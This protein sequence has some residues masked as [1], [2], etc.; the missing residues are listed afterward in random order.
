MRPEENGYEDWYSEE[1]SRLRVR[2]D[3]ESIK[4]DRDR[5]RREEEGE[6]DEE[7]SLC[8]VTLLTH[9]ALS[10]LPPPTRT[11]REPGEAAHALPPSWKSH[12]VFCFAFSSVQIKVKAHKPHLFI[13]G[14]SIIWG[15]IFNHHQRLSQ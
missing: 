7:D 8:S 10:H 15:H 13:G 4:R 2:R 1:E 9:L 5:N 11:S 3:M 14:T 12:G 6:K